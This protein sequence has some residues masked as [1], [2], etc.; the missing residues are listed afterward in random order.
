MSRGLGDVY[1]RQDHVDTAASRLL[2]IEVYREED[3]LDDIVELLERACV[4]DERILGPDDAQTIASRAALAE[5]YRE[6]GRV[7]DAQAVESGR[8]VGVWMPGRKR[9]VRRIPRRQTG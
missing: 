5:A 3:R 8:P 7:E 6:A 1:K 4:D 2:L 9:A